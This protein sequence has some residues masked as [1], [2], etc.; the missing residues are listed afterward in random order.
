MKKYFYFASVA[1]M[2]VALAS[3]EKKPEPTPDPTPDP[4]PETAVFAIQTT[5]IG[6]VT[7]TVSVTPKDS[8]IVYYFD[9]QDVETFTKAYADDAALFEDYTSYF[10]EACDYYTELLGETITWDDL[11]SVGADSYDFEELDPQTKYYAFAFQVDVK[12]KA[13][14]GK[15]EKTEFTTKELVMSD[16]QLTISVAD[17]VATVKTTNNDPYFFYVEPKEDW[18]EYVPNPTQEAIAAEIAEWVSTYKYYGSEPPIFNGDM[19]E[20]LTTEWVKESGEYVVF[21]APY[22][23]T[24]NGTAVYTVCTITVESTEEAPAQLPTK[25]T[26]A[27]KPVKA[28][29]IKGLL[30]K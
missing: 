27:A 20:D 24:V 3:C 14:V 25:K 18:D 4:E 9:V 22:S 11:M 10:D 15:V 26:A 6:A 13:L 5:N 21:A 12:K 23:E 16:N 8:D 29:G 30:K 1:L 7:A 19:T 2:S 17:N 28:Q